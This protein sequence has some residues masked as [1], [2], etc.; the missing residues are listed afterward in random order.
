M[1][2]GDTEA[3]ATLIFHYVAQP[4]SDLGA[5]GRTEVGVVPM[6]SSGHIMHVSSHNR[7][8]HPRAA[9]PDA[10]H[11]LCIVFMFHDVI[12]HRQNPVPF[13]ETL[14]L[15]RA[16]WVHPAHHMPSPARLLLQVE[17]KTPALLSAQQAEARPFQAPGIWKGRE[18]GGQEERGRGGGVA[19]V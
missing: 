13:L 3:K 16:A 5:Q 17:A 18:W 2:V 4:W 7:Q 10:A 12:V 15:G 11:H 9:G 19:Q 14:A 8:Q 6:L 1:A